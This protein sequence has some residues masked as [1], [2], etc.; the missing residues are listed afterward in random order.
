MGLAQPQEHLG[1]LVIGMGGLEELVSCL[2][3]LSL[4]VQCLARRECLFGVG[5]CLCGPGHEGDQNR[6]NDEGNLFV[7]IRFPFE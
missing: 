2:L 4:T 3:E 5:L 7:H 6:Q 1:V